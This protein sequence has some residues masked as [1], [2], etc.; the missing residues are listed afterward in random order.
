MKKIL[1]FTVVLGLSAISFAQ[2]TSYKRMP[3]LGINFF[4]QD[5]KTPA[6]INSSS[7]SDVLANKTWGKGKDMSLGLSLQFLTGMTEHIDFTTS[8]G[9]TLLSYPFRAE[10]GIAVAGSDRL[11]LEWDAGLN[12][13]LLTDKHFLVPYLSAGIGASMYGGTYFGAFMPIGA[14]L[15]FNLGEGVRLNTQMNYRS[16]V[17]V[18]TTNHINYT[19]GFNVNLK[20]RKVAPAV[21]VAPPPPPPP[22][23][24]DTDKD[25]IIDSNDKCP[26]VPGIAKY[27]G[28]PVPDTDGDGINDENDKCPKVKGLAKYEGCPIPDTDKDG[29]NDE[30]DKCPTVA[31]L[32]RYQGCPIPDKD[33]DGINDEEDKCP[34]VKGTAELFGCPYLNFKGQDIK[35][36][37]GSTVLTKSSK[38]ELDK[39][40]KVLNDN[41][42]LKLYVEGHTS[43]TGSA[44]L[45]DK[46]SLDRAFAVKSYL[47]GKGIASDRLTATGF[48]SSKPIADNK[49]K[50]GQDA[51]R[52]VEFHLQE[53]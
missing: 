21:V 45:N 4:L 28:C 29:I 49:T 12:F 11:L 48:G 30:E 32:A 2:T 15:E 36:A 10:S 22:A 20:E 23:P 7:L 27:Q 17:S 35:F 13:K 41:A 51:N 52:R 43:N 5:F 18:L 26:T 47:V 8:L 24:A 53:N 19:L 50:E 42:Q 9:G 34:N 6:L 1:F 25:G 39:G 44:K 33:G 3:S 40:A 31:G 16:Q 14:G 37:N 46:L 38:T